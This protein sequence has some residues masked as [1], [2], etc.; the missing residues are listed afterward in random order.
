MWPKQAHHGEPWH[1]RAQHNGPGDST[2][3]LTLRSAITCDGRFYNLMLSSS[4]SS[5]LIIIT[6][7]IM[8]YNVV[9][10]SA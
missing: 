6:G 1:Q 10:E 7:K 8:S 5:V 4:T 2:I 3:P 9:K